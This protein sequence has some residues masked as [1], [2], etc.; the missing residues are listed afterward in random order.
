MRPAWAGAA[1]VALLGAAA[2]D[3]LHSDTPLSLVQELLLYFA[4]LFCVCMVCHGELVRRKPNPRYLTEFYLLISAG[5]VLGGLLV[6]VVAPL[7]FSSYLEWPIGLAISGV[8]ALGLLNPVR[9][10]GPAQLAYYLGSVLIVGVALYGLASWKWSFGRFRATRPSSA[11]VIFLE[12]LPSKSIT[13]T[14]RI[15]TNSRLVHG[16]ITHGYQF[17]DPVKRKWPTSYYGEQSGVGQAIRYFQHA[18]GVRVGAIGLGTGTLASY[19]GPKDVI[20]LLRNQ[21]G[22]A[23]PGPR[24]F[25]ATWAIAAASGTS[26]MGD[27][28]LSL[29]AEPSQQFRFW[30]SMRS[31][32]MRFRRIR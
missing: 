6:A 4:M 2:N 20:P 16:R 30:S 17:A 28:R 18:G 26:C 22:S 12:S 13:A 9:L 24:T 19:A 3:L 1:V 10:R 15:G 5:G 27:A 14:I 23:P 31:P 11:H 7:V 32:A 25:P 29:E 21:S 8:L